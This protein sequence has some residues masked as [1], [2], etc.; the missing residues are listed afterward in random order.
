MDEKHVKLSVIGFAILLI[1][2]VGVTYAFFNY[3]RTGAANNLRTGRIYFNTTHGEE[4]TITNVFPMTATEASNATLDTVTVG[5]AGDTTYADGEEFEITLVDVT[6]TVNGKH[7]PMNY[8]ATY[9]AATGGS[10]GEASETYFTAR[11][12]KAANIYKLN[13]T[14]K[15]VEGKQVLTGYIKSGATG[16]SGTLSIKAY[17]DADRIAITDTYDPINPETDEMG[18]PYEWVGRREVFT[19]TEWNSLNTNGI[20]FKI[21]AESNEGIWVKKEGSIDT[22]PGCVFTHTFSDLWT[23]WNT[24]NQTPSVLSSDDYYENYQDLIDAKDVYYFLGLKLNASNQIERAYACGL[25]NNITPFC[26]EGDTDGAK[27][28]SNKNLLKR[29]NV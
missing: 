26:I 15:V 7:V 20:S 18:T 24:N 23:T 10:I 28:E 29:G 9:T 2:L 11:D 16:I 27:Y 17:I 25:Y 22:C 12:A 19:T 5:I 3:T 13:T 6:N 4:L 8:I 21:K 1:S 14:G